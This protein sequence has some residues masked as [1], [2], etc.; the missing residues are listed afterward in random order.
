MKKALLVLA[1]LLVTAAAQGAP[2]ISDM[3]VSQQQML[4]R[5]AVEVAALPWKVGDENNYNID[6]GFLKG[7][8]NM[9]VR[10]ISDE[11]IWLDQNVDLGFAGKQVIN[12]LVDQNTG[13]V[14][15]MIVNGR[16]QQPPKAGNMQI[17]E[18]KEDKITVPAG[19]FQVIY[20]KILNKDDNTQIETWVNP[21]DIPISGMAKTIQPAQFGKVTLVLTSFKKN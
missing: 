5:G 7:T 9:K 15:K 21:R 18:Q 17:V 19:T 2:T 14:K 20:L 3:I 16:E 1:G 13:E 4:M 12:V 10:E 11:G 6:M 8:M